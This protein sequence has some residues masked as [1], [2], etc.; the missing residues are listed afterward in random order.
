MDPLDLPGTLEALAPLRTYATEAARG[1]GLDKK[2][3]YH[4]C[5]AIDEIATQFLN[6]KG[7][8][9]RSNVRL[10]VDQNG[11]GCAIVREGFNHLPNHGVV[12]SRRKLPVGVRAGATFAKIHIA[13]SFQRSIAHEPCNVFSTLD[14]VAAALKHN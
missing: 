2:A 1:A 6:R 5:L 9:V 8:Q 11:V 3:T 10:A 12:Q 4:L 13:F 14:D 7:Q